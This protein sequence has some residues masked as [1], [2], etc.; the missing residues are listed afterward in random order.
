M[1]SVQHADIKLLPTGTVLLVD[2]EDDCFKLII[3]HNNVFVS[4]L[5]S[6]TEEERC[7]GRCLLANIIVGEPLIIESEEYATLGMFKTS[8]VKA[9]EIYLDE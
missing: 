3:D 9:I 4:V 2:T 5:D 7:Q 8:P 6:D 1:K